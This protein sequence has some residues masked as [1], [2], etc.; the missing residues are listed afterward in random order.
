MFI[1]FSR[2]FQG[3]GEKRKRPQHTRKQKKLCLP[4]LLLRSTPLTMASLDEDELIPRSSC[5][6][7]AK[8]HDANIML[9]ANETTPIR[10][11]YK[12]DTMPQEKSS[13]SS[14]SSVL[15]FCV[16]RHVVANELGGVGRCVALHNNDPNEPATLNLAYPEHLMDMDLALV[17]YA[18]LTDVARAYEQHPIPGAARVAIIVN[19]RARLVGNIF[20]ALSWTQRLRFVMMVDFYCTSHNALSLHFG[21]ALASALVHQGQFVPRPHEWRADPVAEDREG[22][23]PSW[24][25]C[26]AGGGSCR[27]STPISIVTDDTD[28]SE[29]EQRTRIAWKMAQVPGISTSYP[30]GRDIPMPLAK[31]LSKST[32]RTRLVSTSAITDDEEGLVS[33]RTDQGL[34]TAQVVPHD[35]EAF[36]AEAAAW[37]AHMS[38]SHPDDG[39]T[40]TTTNETMETVVSEAKATAEVVAIHDQGF[41]H[42]LHPQ[43][44]HCMMQLAHASHLHACSYR[45]LFALDAQNGSMRMH[46][47]YESYWRAMPRTTWL[48]WQWV[49]LMSRPLI[50]IGRLE[51]CLVDLFS[52]DEHGTSNVA[53]LVR[54]TRLFEQG[55][56]TSTATTTYTQHPPT[57]TNQ[58][59]IVQQQ[60]KADIDT[61]SSIPCFVDT[62]HLFWTSL[63]AFVGLELALSNA[64]DAN[65]NNF[66]DQ[67]LAMGKH[68][69][70]ASI[71]CAGGAVARNLA[72]PEA[73]RWMHLDTGTY[74]SDCDFFIVGTDG[75]AKERLFKRILEWF[76]KRLGFLPIIGVLPGVFT[77]LL[78]H[79]RRFMQFVI[80]DARTAADLIFHY[81]FGYI[82]VGGTCA[83]RACKRADPFPPFTPQ[84]IISAARA[85]LTPKCICREDC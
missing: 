43:D 66:L 28:V 26:H 72:S 85:A 79:C 63:Q 76:R 9:P 14:S 1:S 50:R 35:S 20:R 8:Q 16:P 18:Y 54:N 32:K 59:W 23:G 34:D 15:E 47:A 84:V 60:Q 77:I 22:R 4:R 44:Y 70:F 81:D 12:R 68:D 37:H 41:F 65:T 74:Q 58:C 39:S 83:A 57:K 55:E 27:R 31:T 19:L 36:E 33:K 38:H 75:P 62:R 61:E 82:Q 80:S 21:H 3:K 10:L 5:S 56:K 17:L 48:D 40:T 29:D 45:P 30:L 67:L 52:T 2:C 42:E 24:L 51:A 78:P 11:V 6:N 49:E 69:A 71:A 25:C 53:H 13:S 73:R 46:D 7:A 64:T